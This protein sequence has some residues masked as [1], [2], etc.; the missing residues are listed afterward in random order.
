[1]DIGLGRCEDSLEG[2]DDV[3]GRQLSAV[4]Q[5]AGGVVRVESIVDA[6][7]DVEDEMSYFG[8]LPGLG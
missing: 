1:M 2:V 4:D 6:L 5:F 8:E 3:S 7:S